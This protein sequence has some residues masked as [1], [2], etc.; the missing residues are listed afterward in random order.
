M[1]ISNIGPGMLIFIA[2][3]ALIIF[4]PKRLPE[5]G[6]SFGTT[7]REFKK[8]SREIMWDDSVD[9]SKEKIEKIEPSQTTT[10]KES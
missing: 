1:M 5:L 2:I 10:H 7:I 3:T 6:K 8:G 9:E 4:G